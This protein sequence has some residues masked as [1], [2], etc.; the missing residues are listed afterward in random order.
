V[1]ST[2]DNEIAEGA[3]EVCAVLEALRRHERSVSEAEAACG[4]LRKLCAH[5][6]SRIKLA[7]NG[8]I[9]AVLGATVRRHEGLEGVAFAACGALKTLSVNVENVVNVVGEGGIGA[10]LEVLRSV[11]CAGDPQFSQSRAHAQNQSGR[12]HWCYG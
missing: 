3:A 9:G 1:S 7:A 6:E 11:P 8:G 2:D 12:G 10:V 5:D 4:A